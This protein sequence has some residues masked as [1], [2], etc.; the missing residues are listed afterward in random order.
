MLNKFPFFISQESRINE[1]ASWASGDVA[2]DRKPRNKGRRRKL[3]GAGKDARLA[4][5]PAA[6]GDKESEVTPGGSEPSVVVPRPQP[7]SEPAPDNPDY[8]SSDDGSEQLYQK[9]SSADQENIR[10]YIE[11]VV[12]VCYNC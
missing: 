5:Q 4:Y 3:W 2:K 11:H 9:P 7:V 1:H 8:E 6:L 10:R 12:Q